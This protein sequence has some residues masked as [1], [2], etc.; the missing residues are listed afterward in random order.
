MTTES[1]IDVLII[2][3]GPAGSTCAWKLARAG[4]ECLVLDKEEFPRVK[5]C[6][7]WV[8]PDVINDLEIDISAYPHR[9]LTFDHIH[10]R[11]PLMGFNPH[12][13]QHSIRRYEFD[14][15]LLARSGAEVR[16]HNVHNIRRDGEFYVIDDTYRC[17]YLVGAGGTRCP[18]YRS[19]F[20]K[21]N[22]RAKDLQAVTLEKE[23]P[24][25]YDDDRCHL[26]FFEHG[27]PGYSW[28]VPKAD[29]YLNVGIGAMAARLKQRGDDIK[30]HWARLVEKL[31]RAGMVKDYVPEPKGYSYFIRGDV[32]VGHIDN[33]F[34][35]GDAAGLATRDLCEGIGPAVKS[36]LMAADSII[37]GSAYRLNAIDTYSSPSWLVRKLIEHKLHAGAIAATR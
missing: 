31:L 27:L 6:A 34:I 5:L 37:N 35:L 26:W 8:T 16:Q 11:F 36:G 18:V 3:G 15:W 14:E 7:G 29:G 30:P 23:F 33:A 32:R 25:P 4:V 20:R 2:G 10:F 19:L 28:Y 17:R 21:A 12:T 22:P 13:V 24:Y 9:F 1:V